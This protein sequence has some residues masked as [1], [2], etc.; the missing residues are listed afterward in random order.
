MEQSAA[1]TTQVNKAK[2]G[3]VGLVL[4]R[5]RLAL[6]SALTP[7]REGH[8]ALRF[9]ECSPQVFFRGGGNFFNKDLKHITVL[10][11][12]EHFLS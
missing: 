6:H 9:S 10:T 7:R 11:L 8:S 3:S 12:L 4:G 1:L 5:G 2:W